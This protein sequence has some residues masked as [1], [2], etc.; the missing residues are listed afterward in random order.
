MKGLLEKICNLFGK[1]AKFENILYYGYLREI[2]K[3]EFE[4]KFK[5]KLELSD[6]DSFNQFERELSTQILYNSRITYL[7]YQFF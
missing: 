4:R 1:E 5:G 2:N 3:V 7:K 6:N